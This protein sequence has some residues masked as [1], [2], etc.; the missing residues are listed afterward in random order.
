MGGNYIPEV[1]FV[2]TPE[3]VVRKML[4]LADLKEK[5]FQRI[6]LLICKAYKYL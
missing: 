4:K 1:P 6:P 2:P 3:N 5:N